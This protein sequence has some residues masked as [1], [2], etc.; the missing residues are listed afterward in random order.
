MKGLILKDLYNIGRNTKQMLFVLIFMG[1]C[2]VPTNGAEGYIVVCSVLGCMMVVTTFSID[3]RSQWMKYALVTPISPDSYVKA[4]YIGAFLFSTISLVF[5]M[6]LAFL[7]GLITHSF[8]APAFLGSSGAGFLAALFLEAL[9][10]PILFCFGAEQAR[11]IMIAVVAVPSLIFY[12]AYKL[13]AFWEITLTR[14][15][16]LYLICAAPVAVILLLIL[17][18]NISLKCFLKKEF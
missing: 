9:Y 8:S 15:T 4:K 2:L 6:L 10:L 11:I 14:Q 1:I 13:M 18:Y 16:T 12:S 5:G 17:T 3:E 7:Y